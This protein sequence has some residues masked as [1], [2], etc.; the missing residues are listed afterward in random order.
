MV[1]KVGLRLN[2]GPMRVVSVSL[3][4][5]LVDE[6]DRLREKGAYTGRSEAVR[7]ALRPFLAQARDEAERAG[8]ATATMT[9]AY[10]ERV[11]DDVNRRRHEYSEVIQT[12]VHGHTSEHGCL[13]VLVLEGPADRIRSL[14]ESLRG[15]KG[16]HRVEL[17]WL[18]A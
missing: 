9:L 15:R 14:G 13:E 1:H 6:L 10:D 16:I 8:E 5:P 3:P 2:N 11:G 18:D 7:A 4:E 12:M 17:V